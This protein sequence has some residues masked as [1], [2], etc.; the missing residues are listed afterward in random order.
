MSD[1]IHLLDSVRALAIIGVI[2]IHVT[3][4]VMSYRG[5]AV[6]GAANGLDLTF[7]AIDLGLIIDKARA[8]FG[9]LFGVSFA[10]LIERAEQRG[11]AV[12][13]FFMRRMAGL[14]LF[15]IINQALFFFGDIL[16]T[17]A[18]LGG[19]LLL[20]RRISDR[21]VL[22]TALTLVALSPAAAAVAAGSG[23]KLPALAPTL[24]SW[25]SSAGAAYDGSHFGAVLRQNLAYPIHR[26]MSETTK[27]ALWTLGVLGLFLLG[28]WT[29]RRGILF[30]V[31][32]HRKFLV[33]VAWVALPTGVILVIV[34][35]AGPFLAGE[36]GFGRPITALLEL[37]A[38][39]GP[40]M[41][42]GYIA[43][44]AL[45]FGD[46]PGPVQRVLAP[47]GRMSLTAYL[48]STA[49]VGP[50]VY[51][52]GLGIGATIGLTGLNLLALAVVAALLTFAHLWLGRFRFG[53]LEWAWRSLT[54][55]SWQ[56]LRLDPAEMAQPIQ[57]R[58]IDVVWPTPNSLPRD[59]N[60]EALP[61]A[62]YRPPE[63]HRRDLP[64]N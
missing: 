64:D 54:Y 38:L 63:S 62:H 56:A 61:N 18:L 34:Q 1:R 3:G 19:V 11:A 30:N 42:M 25:D 43:V 12:G 40:V 60:E 24:P 22:A 59:R 50:I 29:A 45:L 5:G 57:A 55:G 2:V 26:W 16:V 48:A 4:M 35:Q 46:R 15:G 6:M 23:W 21:T 20:F 49:I 10:I 8:C 13:N 31:S 37:A 27:T 33:A 41:G 44:F 36:G 58:L 47:L 52:Y 53:P 14:L 7:A 39:G 17:Y 28:L 9:F 51:G 32:Q